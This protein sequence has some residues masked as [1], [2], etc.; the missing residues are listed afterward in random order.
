[1]KFLPNF[2]NEIL[3]WYFLIIKIWLS[4]AKTYFDESKNEKKNT[5]KLSRVLKKLPCSQQQEALLN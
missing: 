2:K 5:K 4:F 3:R 1:M